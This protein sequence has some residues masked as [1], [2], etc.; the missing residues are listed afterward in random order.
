MGTDMFFLVLLPHLPGKQLIF[1]KRKLSEYTSLLSVTPL[2]TIFT[3]F[4]NYTCT[5]S[6]IDAY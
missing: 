1:P 5:Q 6:V 2:N 3:E 4:N